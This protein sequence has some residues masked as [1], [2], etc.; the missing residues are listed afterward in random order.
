MGVSE[1]TFPPSN[2][3]FLTDNMDILSVIL[4]INSIPRAIVV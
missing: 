1:L 4:S 2:S 3:L